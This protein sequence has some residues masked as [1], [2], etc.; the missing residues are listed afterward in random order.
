MSQHEEAE[1]NLTNFASKMKRMLFKKTPNTF[2]M[3]TIAG[4]KAVEEN[5]R[6]VLEKLK[7]DNKLPT[8][9]A[10]NAD[11]DEIMNIIYEIQG[12]VWESGKGQVNPNKY[13]DDDLVEGFDEV[14]DTAVREHIY[15]EII[16]FIGEN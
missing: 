4:G 5:T 14:H 7:T 6:K 9:I 12:L 10:S 16:R 1:Q 3:F 15:K 2:G 13:D 8:T 11:Q